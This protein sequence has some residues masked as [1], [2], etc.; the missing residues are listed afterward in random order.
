MPQK[1]QDLTRKGGFLKVFLPTK[2]C[3]EE[4]SHRTSASMLSSI[5]EKPLAASFVFNFFISNDGKTS[6]VIS[7]TQ[8]LTE[9][10][11][12]RG[13]KKITKKT[14]LKIQSSKVVNELLP[15]FVPANPS[16][17]SS[18]SLS[19]ASVARELLKLNPENVLPNYLRKIL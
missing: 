18:I 6:S 14:I 10:S 13:D 8:R 2:V 19:K 1:W 15:T 5:I 17:G 7:S 9:S 11:P 12:C 4:P 3:K 16:K